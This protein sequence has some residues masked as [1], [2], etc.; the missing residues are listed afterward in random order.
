MTDR[1]VRF[2]PHFFDE[3][4]SQL[5]DQRATDGTPSAADF[6]LYDL[7]RMRDRLASDFERNTLEVSGTDVRVL[8]CSGTLVHTVAIYAFIDHDE[9]V[10]VIAIDIQ[11][12]TD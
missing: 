9:A 5:P 7:P 12:A 11:T 4:D 2:H 8:I 3:L 6:L 1:L 10:E